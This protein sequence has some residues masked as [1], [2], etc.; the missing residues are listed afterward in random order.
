MASIKV[1]NKTEMAAKGESIYATLKEKL[2]KEHRGEFVAIE[3]DSGDY[4]LGQTLQEADKKAR[5]K[6]PD[7]VFYVIRIGRRAVW[8]RR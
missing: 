1:I 7:R 3:V 2:E 4:F 8:V 5:Q 6:Y